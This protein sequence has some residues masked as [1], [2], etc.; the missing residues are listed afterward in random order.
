MKKNLF[1]LLIL[2]STKAFCFEALGIN[3]EDTFNTLVSG[4]IYVGG[5]M[6]FAS[7]I[8]GIYTWKTGRGENGLSW[9]LFGIFCGII[10]TNSE[11]ILNFFTSSG[12][13]F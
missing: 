7:F 6:S 4:I 9:I 3:F 5:T 13:T 10:S 1:I 11:K 12:F 2:L 8:W